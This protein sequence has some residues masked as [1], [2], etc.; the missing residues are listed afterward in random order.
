MLYPGNCFVFDEQ[1]GN[2]RE[3]LDKGDKIRLYYF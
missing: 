3:T 1:L 2:I